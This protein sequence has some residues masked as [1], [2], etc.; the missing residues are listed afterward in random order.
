MSKEK[1][2]TTNY[3]NT[4]IEVSEDTK[5]ICGTKPPSKGEK[6]TVGELQYEL[7]Q[8]NRYIYTSDD[9][10]FQVYALR[11]KVSENDYEK[12]RTVF[13]S[14]GQPCLRSTPLAKT[15]GFGIHHNNEG[16]IALFG[17][18]TRQYKNLLADPAIKKVKAMRSSRK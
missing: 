18:E 14:K 3:Y 8:N 17:M 5:A 16:K 9:I 6:K 2:H 4:L 13:F 11:N 12:A 10:I 7:I 1:L 15:Y